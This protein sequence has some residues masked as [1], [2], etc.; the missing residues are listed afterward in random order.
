M[1]PSPK[2][3]PWTPSPLPG[4]TTR[5]TAGLSA[6]T[7]KSSSSRQL[8]LINFILPVS[9]DPDDDQAKI[10]RELS[11][12]IRQTDGFSQDYRPRTLGKRGLSPEELERMRPGIV[13]V[14]LSASSHVGPWASRRGFDTVVQTVSGITS[15]QGELFPGAAPGPQSYPRSAIDYLNGY[16]MAF[17]GLVAPARRV[18][19]GGSWLVKVSLAQTGHWLVGRGQVPDPNSKTCP[20]SRGSRGGSNPSCPRYDR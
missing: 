10:S 14:S 4:S 12:L 16:L 1:C 20:T 9:G 19:E 8:L 18:R 7:C 11:G 5:V 17:G 13:Y 6:A 3:R 2:C 15:R